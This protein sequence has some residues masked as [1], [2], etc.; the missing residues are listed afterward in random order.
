MA[1]LNGISYNP[2]MTKNIKNLPMNN[3]PIRDILVMLLFLAVVVTNLYWYQV[4]LGLSK[5]LDPVNTNDY[6]QFVQIQ[7]LKACVDAGTRP[8]DVELQQ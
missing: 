7:K 1:T 5:R 8:C 2:P 6:K 3:L 4:T